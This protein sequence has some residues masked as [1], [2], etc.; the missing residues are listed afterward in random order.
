MSKRTGKSVNSIWNSIDDVLGKTGAAIQ[1]AIQTEY[2]CNG[3]YQI[4]GADIVFD[5]NANPYL[6]EVNTSPS[7]ERK[8]LLADGFE[9]VV[10]CSITKP[11]LSSFFNF[12]FRPGKI[13]KNINIRRKN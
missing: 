10:L 8:N 2:S 6:L 9:R 12:I 1:P 13:F 5:T 11:E 3:C 7:I 4:W